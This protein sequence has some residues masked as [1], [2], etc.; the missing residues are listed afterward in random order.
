M[1]LTPRQLLEYAE[2][3]NLEA[4]EAQVR[5]VISRAYYALLLR[6]K[7]VT[8][9]EFFKPSSNKETTHAEVIG[10]VERHGASLQPGRTLAKQ[11]AQNLTKLRVDRVISDYQLGETVTS[12]RAKPNLERARMALGWC[13]QIYQLLRAQKG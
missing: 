13:D 1:S 10:A 4:S 11:V 2:S 9:K 3:L 8:P 5:T 12:Q 7:E 6:A